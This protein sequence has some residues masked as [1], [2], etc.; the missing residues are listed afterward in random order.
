[1][2]YNYVTFYVLMSFFLITI[3]LLQR[4]CWDLFGYIH[5]GEFVSY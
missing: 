5:M 3:S 4:A 1:M 2:I